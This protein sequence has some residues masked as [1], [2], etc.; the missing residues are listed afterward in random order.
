MVAQRDMYTIKSPISGTVDAVNVKEG[1]A[2]APGANG[3]HVVSFDKLKVQA[4]LGENYLGDVK[5]NDP[6]NL[7]FTDIGDT[8]H[9]RLNYVGQS[10]DPISRAFQVEVWLGANKNLHPNMSCK[11]QIANYH[12]KDALTVPVSVIQ[13]TAQGDMLYIVDGGDKAK[14][15]PIKAGQ[16]SN[17]QVEILSGL[18]PGDKVIT[19]GFEDVYEGQKV[20]IQ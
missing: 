14:A 7:I 19:E 16:N 18:K 3:I 15:V 12:K 1:E 11:M 4:T 9:T 13:H 17:G 5:Q 6:V 2:A 10:V 8:M 20:S